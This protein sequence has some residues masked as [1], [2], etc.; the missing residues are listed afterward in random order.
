MPSTGM[1]S[2]D[3]PSGHMPSHDMP[4]GHMPSGGPA[5]TY[6]GGQPMPR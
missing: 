5:G 1:P 4:S 3:M 2:H 6:P